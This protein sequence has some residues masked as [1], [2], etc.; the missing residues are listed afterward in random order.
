VDGPFTE[1]RRF[2]R[3]ATANG[4]TA[5]RPV[6][7]T[8]QLLDLSSDGLL[9]ACE[10]PLAIAAI[11]RVVSWLAGRRLEVELVV[12]HVSSRWVDGAGGYLVG[13][14][15]PALDPPAR[16]AI[17]TLLAATARLDAGEPAS[18]AGRGRSRPPAGDGA[19]SKVPNRRQNR[20]PP[21]RGPG[22]ARP[23]RADSGFAGERGLRDAGVVS[24]QVAAS[25]PREAEPSHELDV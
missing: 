4:I 3:V 8:V 12:R 13:G 18:R 10:R 17:D 7:M 16:Q 14:R 19:R 11:P 15:F 22:F 2:P 1:R 25:S 5:T 23:D 6:S 20:L 9:L 21:K 24:R